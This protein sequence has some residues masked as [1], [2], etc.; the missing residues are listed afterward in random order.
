M[1]NKLVKTS[2]EGNK[3]KRASR[4][5]ASKAINVAVMVIAPI[6]IYFL[7]EFMLRNPFVKM[8][9]Q[10][11]CLNMLFWEFL[12]FVLVTVIGRLSAAIITESIFAMIV[13]VLNYYVISFR[14]APVQPWDIM[15]AKV[16]ASVAA[17]YDY[18]ME[19]RVIIC[20]IGLV[21]VCVGGYFCKLKM[22]RFI[23]T[24]FKIG[25]VSTW[26][27]KEKDDILAFMKRFL[28]AVVSIAILIGY[29]LLVMQDSTVKTFRI[30]DKLFTPL[31][32]TYKDGTAVA[33]IIEAKYMNVDKPDGYSDAKAANMLSEYEYDKMTT[34][35]GNADTSVKPN[36]IVI[37]NE[38]FSDLSVLQDY[39]T[40][41]DEMPFV[42]SLLAGNDNT[43]SGYMDVSVLGG[44]TANTEYEFLTGDSMA[45][46][47]QGSIPYQQYI[48]GDTESM[49]SVFKSNGYDAVAIHPYNATGW[50][51][52]KVYDYF[53]FDRF[54]AQDEFDNPEILRKYISDRCDYEK[55]IDVLEHKDADKPIF[56]F[57]VTMQNHSSYTDEFDNFVPEISVDGTD[58][59]AT[60]QYLSL[61]HRSDEAFKELVE[62][63]DAK[64]E[65]VIL[66]FFGD[67][68]PTDSVVEPLYKLNGE[69][70]YSLS[71]EEKAARYKVPYVIWS[72][73][74]IEEA[75]GA[76]SSPNF[77]GA[78]VMELAGVQTSAYENYINQLSERYHSISV[79]Q[80]I[81]AEGN[82]MSVDNAKDNLAD[83]QLLQYYHLFKKAK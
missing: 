75:S 41:E 81:D 21:C 74:D 31:T 82:R 46:L 45:W 65:P 63:L 51:R 3:A 76:V 20:I 25:S 14:G 9:W 80:S 78:K 38:A 22:P 10:I 13:G 48:K 64:D 1:S 77:L 19:S 16:A 26:R 28:T 73:T 33:F 79:M 11:Q 4:F 8:K 35:S 57:N 66:V 71:D 36:V 23:P 83:Y 50:C 44:N 7:S 34:V 59:V 18:H 67:H 53:G 6:A 32:M 72:N 69:S 58:N 39:T 62:Y 29:L 49:A 5:D 56:I 17:D 54:I 37:M 43:I 40:N 15:S 52:D 12:M 27:V 24:G 42:R 70:V 55:V 30:Y 68:Q 60:N 47:P 61:I 2:S